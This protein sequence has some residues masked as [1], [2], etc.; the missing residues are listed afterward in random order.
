MH[1]SDKSDVY[2]YGMVDAVNTKMSLNL[3]RQVVF[4]VSC[5]EKVCDKNRTDRILVRS[6]WQTLYTI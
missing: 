3:R 4:E 5:G 1:F 2:S 6:Y